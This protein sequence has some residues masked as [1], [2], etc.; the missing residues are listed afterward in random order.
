MPLDQKAAANKSHGGSDLIDS[1]EL[2]SLLDF[3]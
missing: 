3:T 2:Q 1:T